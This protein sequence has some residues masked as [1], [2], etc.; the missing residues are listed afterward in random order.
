MKWFKR[1]AKAA[2]DEAI[3]ATGKNSTELTVRA[4]PH[5]HVFPI[6]ST[7]FG[8]DPYFEE[9]DRW[10]ISPKDSRP[11]DFLCQVN[12]NDC[13][14]RPDVPFDLF[15]VFLSWSL[16]ESGDC[17]CIAYPYSN[18]S[19]SKAI[20]IPRPEPIS[21]DDYRVRPC[22]VSTKSFMTYP[23]WS[24]ERI[25]EVAIAAAEFRDRATAI[26]S[27]LRR[28]GSLRDYRSRI[29]GHPTWVHDNTL[30]QINDMV[31]LAQIDYEPAAN[32]SIGDAT[33]VYLAVSASSPMCIETD[34][35]Q[36]F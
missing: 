26:N 25:P 18:V 4:A 36:T 22:I 15:T 34:T 21:D 20:S 30:E 2:L 7:H 10:P 9:N 17:N 3:R 1:G 6:T 24:I 29:G 27:S 19:A 8:G 11:Y 14:E 33:P 16:S 23:T 13:P 35:W 28:L 5:D 12:L 31:F 32:N